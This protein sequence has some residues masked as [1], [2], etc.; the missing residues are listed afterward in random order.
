MGTWQN[1]LCLRIRIKGDWSIKKRIVIRFF[2][3]T[4]QKYQM[5][6]KRLTIKWLQQPFLIQ[7]R[8]HRGTNGGNRLAI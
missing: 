8:Q 3:S 2:L 1:L 6:A 5:Y 7:S 4:I